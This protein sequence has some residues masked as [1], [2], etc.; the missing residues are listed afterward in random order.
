MQIQSEKQ[1]GLN[2]NN[3]YDSEFR[4]DRSE[5]KDNFQR[6][7]FI[8]YKASE[9]DI[10]SKITISN[11]FRE[12]EKD[13]FAPLNTQRFRRYGN[14]LILPWEKQKKP[15]WLPTTKTDDGKELSGYD[16]GNNNPEHESIRYFNALSD[17]V[18]KSKYLNSIIIEDYNLTFGLDE[19]YLPIYVG[20]HFVK[21]V[22]TSDQ[23]L[24]I[25]SPNCFH[26]DGEPFTFAHLFYRSNNIVGGENYIAHPS[27]R[28]K[29]IEDINIEN[30]YSQFTLQ[31]ISDSF[32]VH[33]S[34]VCH[35]VSPIKKIK[36]AQI[37]LLGERWMILIDYSLTKQK[38]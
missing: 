31:N 16:Q 22:S 13:P 2:I 38:I 25:S 3:Q 28:N 10:N 32:A 6:D 36:N 35:Y 21:L 26:Q 1:E 23:H 4:I 15:I 12:L 37:D 18:K 9:V 5:L 29:R 20:I 7:G 34:S 27:E 33:D 8:K 24:G 30:V 11:E 14:A 19:Y 17:N